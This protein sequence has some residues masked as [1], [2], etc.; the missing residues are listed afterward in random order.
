MLAPSNPQIQNPRL[1]LRLRKNNW[2]SISRYSQASRGLSVQILEVRIF[3]DMSISPSLSLRQYLYDYAFRA[4]HNLRD[5]E[6]R[7][8]RPVRVTAAVYW[9]LGLKP[10][11]HLPLILQHWAGVSLYTSFYKLAETCVF[12][13]Q[14]LLPILCQ[15]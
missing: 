13:K 10:I 9:G 12:I 11:R 8:L 5:K 14:S 3:T 4:G 7:Y 6:F 2:K 15:L 1:P